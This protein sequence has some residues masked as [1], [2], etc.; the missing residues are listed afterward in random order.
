MTVMASY[1]PESITVSRWESAQREGSKETIPEGES[2]AVE[3]LED[4]LTFTA[5]PGYIYEIIGAWPEGEVTYGF[6]AVAQNS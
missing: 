5:E 4:G 3:E 1:K 6:E 2:V